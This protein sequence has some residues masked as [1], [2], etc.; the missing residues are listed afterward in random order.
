MHIASGLHNHY[1]ELFTWMASLNFWNALAQSL[2]KLSLSLL[3][4]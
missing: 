1:S 4:T 2:L 3:Q